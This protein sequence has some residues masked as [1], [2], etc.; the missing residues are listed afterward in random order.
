MYMYHCQHSVVHTAVVNMYVLYLYSVMLSN[1]VCLTQTK[2][3][4]S[5]V[6]VV[7]DECNHLYMYMGCMRGHER[8]RGSL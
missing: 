2:H 4:V 5:I 8:G 6:C 1:G 3:D 7:T